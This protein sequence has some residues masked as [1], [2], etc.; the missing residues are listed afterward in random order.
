MPSANW[1]REALDLILNELSDADAASPRRCQ[2]TLGRSM[3]LQWQEKT[4]QQWL[5]TPGISA[6][7]REG[8]LLMLTRVKEELSH[9]DRLEQKAQ[10]ER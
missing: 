3:D 8:L 1:G 7:A 4:I 5:N 10:R 2:M 6:D 9:T